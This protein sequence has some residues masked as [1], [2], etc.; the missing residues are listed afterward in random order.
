[1][2]TAM[3]D[4]E[5]LDTVLRV[6]RTDRLIGAHRAAQVMVYEVECGL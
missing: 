2:L 3:R 6:I 1:M 5:E 4:G